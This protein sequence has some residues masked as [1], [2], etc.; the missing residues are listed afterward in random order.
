LLVVAVGGIAGVIALGSG[1]GSKNDEPVTRETPPPP[2]HAPPPASGAS[3]AIALSALAGSWW[4]EGGVEY[5]GAVTDDAVELR[6]H[7]GEMLPGLGYASGEVVFVLRPL[8]GQ[9]HDFKVEARVRPAPPRGFVYDRAR[10]SPSCVGAFTHADGKELRAVEAIDRLVV[11]TVKI[12]PPATAFTHEGLRVVRCAGVGETHAAQAETVLGRTPTQAPPK[13]APVHDAGAHDGGIAGGGVHDAGATGGAH[14]AGAHDA[15]SGGAIG[16]ACQS[17]AQCRS[18]NCFMHH[19]LPNG[20]GFG[21][22]CSVDGQCQSHH[23]VDSMC[24]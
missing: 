4:G 14:D 21:A 8:A 5:E 17:D 12:D 15:R 20:K 3:R 23:C 24:K 13:W 19:C 1:D 9:D 6:L 22:P 16:S 2:T 11:Q 7:D 18:G 10:S